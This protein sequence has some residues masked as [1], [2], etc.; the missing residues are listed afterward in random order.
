MAGR[1]L[2]QNQA[3]RVEKLQRRRIEHAA[4]EPDPDSPALDGV[5]ISRFG[6]RVDVED[7]R[8]AGTVCRCH[9]RS[10]IDSLVAGD[11]VVWHR[12][13]E[14]GIVTARHER[15][16][17]LSRPDMHGTLRPAAANLDRIVIVI[18]PEPE[19]HA[20]L[21]DRYLAAAEDV[22]LQ[23]LILLNKTDLLTDPA[24]LEALLGVYR[25]IGYPV[26]YASAHAGGLDELQAALAG[27]TTAFV[28]QSGVGKSSLISA[29]L[30]HEQDIR[31]GELSHAVT[32]GRHTTTAARL[33]HLPA[34]GDLIDSPGIREFSL[35][36]LDAARTAH[37]FVEFRPH[38]GR[39]RFRD[40]VHRNEP[41]CALREAVA[42]GTVSA[43]R[44]A[45]FLQ[46]T[47]EPS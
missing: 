1:K 31:I 34:G 9:M 37:G 11:R 45:S 47:G 42:A 46:I 43:A 35:A 40:C 41:G 7:P 6:K 18:A 39:C 21:L 28:G 20:N 24:A 12:D 38:L 5:V 4:S 22:G 29:L 2:S 25:A 14:G 10:T 33:Y 19:P 16:T 23:A 26:L 27:H 44:Y 32:K 30:P 36:H 8:A 17:V 3:R 13:G 15:A